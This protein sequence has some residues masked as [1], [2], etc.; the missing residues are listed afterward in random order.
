MRN[1]TINRFKGLDTRLGMYG[2]DSFTLTIGENLSL[3]SAGTIRRRPSLDKI[4]DL[5]SESVGLYARGGLLHSVVP[6][7]RSYQDLHPPEVIYD[8]IGTATGETLAGTYSFTLAGGQSVFTTTITYNAQYTTALV[9]VFINGVRLAVSEYS[10]DNN[11][12]FLRVT[13]VVGRAAADIFRADAYLPST[14]VAYPNGVLDRLVAA[15]TYGTDEIYGP[16]G[17]VCVSRNDGKPNEHHWLKRPPML[18]SIPVNT[19]ILLGF[20]PGNSITKL[21][22]KFWVPAPNE[23]TIRFDSTLGPD[24]WDEPDDAGF[25]PVLTHLSGS[26]DVLTTNHYRSRLAVFFRDAVQ[27]WQVNADPER[28]LLEQVLNGPGAFLAGAV[29]N[30]QGDVVYL[31]DGGFRTLSTATVTGEADAGDIGKEI[32][33]LTDLIGT[34]TPAVTLWSEARSQ[35]ICCIGT[36]AYVLTW[37]AV[38]RRVDWTTWTLPVAIEYLV[39]L[40]RVLYAR[41]GDVL[42]KFTDGGAT[43]AGGVTITSTFQT[44]QLAL[45]FPGKLKTLHYMVI[46]QTTAATW[47]IIVDGMP[48][49]SRVVP[50][51]SPQSIR[52]PIAGEGRQ[53]AFKVTATA[54]WRLEGFSIDFEAQEF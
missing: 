34:S 54:D 35:F 17:Y 22:T 6:G 28:I 51:C 44:N 11:A 14:G 36:T 7:G 8:P 48:L 38:E 27:L 25:I 24:N 39:E 16:N 52:I 53:I 13:L 50:A 32:K 10:V 43:D 9:H 45:G 31:S 3:L 15:D 1:F 19:L 33:S 37:I 47:T 30:V 5:H 29:A 42:Y 2:E 21:E 4:T 26:R 18:A 40:D 46:R 49:R 41:S 20:V 12:G 23:G